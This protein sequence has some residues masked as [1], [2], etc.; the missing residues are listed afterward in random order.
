M[1]TGNRCAPN[2]APPPAAPGSVKPR[3]GEP[4]VGEQSY[5]GLYDILGSGGGQMQSRHRDSFLALV[6][7]ALC[8][9]AAGVFSGTGVKA[10][11]NPDDPVNQSVKAFTKVYD[12]VEQNFADVIHFRERLDALVHRVVRV[13]CRL[14][15]GSTEN[16]R[17]ER[18]QGDENR[19]EEHTSELQSREK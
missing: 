8:S 4:R 14:Y 7:I 12:V 19:S 2:R 11:S 15:T 10:A 6:F 13:A 16:A 9:L 3:V 5:S 1:S 18:A 17:G